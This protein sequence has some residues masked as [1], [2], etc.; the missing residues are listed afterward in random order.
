[1][2]AEGGLDVSAVRRAWPDILELVKGKSR[3]AWMVLMEGVQAASIE[4]TVLT[5]AFDQEGKRKN[6]VN[7]GRDTVVREA[8]KEFLGVDWRIETVTGAAPGPAAAPA[9]APSGQ[10]GP[11]RA[12]QG[13]RGPRSGGAGG[14]GAGGPAGAG[15][16]S[17]TAVPAPPTSVG[18]AGPPPPP[19]PP[20]DE[21]PPPPPS[22][23]EADEVDP[24]GDANADGDG[25]YSG[26][27]LIQRELGGQVIQEIDNSSS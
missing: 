11:G 10:P 19:P 7:G 12:G 22:F 20:P 13:G 6:F 27:A 18:E 15:P 8:L 21:P 16:M 9:A 26:M 5:L 23:D 4:G 2:P 25:A 3:A 14:P 17:G 24:E 1:V